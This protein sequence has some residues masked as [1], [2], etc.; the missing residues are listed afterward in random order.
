MRAGPPREELS[1]DE[2]LLSDIPDRLRV[3]DWKI[4]EAHSRVYH[5]LMDVRARI[6]ACCVY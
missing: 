2:V 3:E 4:C 1:I 6:E 5:G